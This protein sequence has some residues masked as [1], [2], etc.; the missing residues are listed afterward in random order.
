MLRYQFCL[1]E[2]AFEQETK[3]L[4]KLRSLLSLTY[5]VLIYFAKTNVIMK[6]L[7]FNDNFFWRAFYDINFEIIIGHLFKSWSNLQG[8]TL[9]WRL[10][11]WTRLRRRTLWCGPSDYRTSPMEP[12]GTSTFWRSD[13]VNLDRHLEFH[14]YFPETNT[15]TVLLR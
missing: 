6:S 5:W 3:S 15:K 14:V 4:E 2:L 1:S 10:S 9:I 8:P 12:L 13:P 11:C 7:F